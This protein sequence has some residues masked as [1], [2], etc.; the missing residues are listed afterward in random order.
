MEQDEQQQ[1]QLLNLNTKEF[2]PYWVNEKQPLLV[3]DNPLHYKAHKLQ[4]LLELLSK[5]AAKNPA[6][7]NSRNYIDALNEYTRCINSIKEGKTDDGLDE[8]SVD[9][10]SPRSKTPAV[11]EGVAAGVDSGVSTDNP[12]A[13]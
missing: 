3:P 13:R 8:G 10:D 4:V 1:G 6:Q 2:N 9:Q 11:G 5:Q 7:F 12:L